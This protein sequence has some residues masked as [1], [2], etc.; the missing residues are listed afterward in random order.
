MTVISVSRLPARNAFLVATLS[1]KA[2]TIASFIDTSLVK[3]LYPGYD[4][5]LLAARD[6][7]IDGQ[8]E[9]LTCGT[10]SLGK[11]APFVAKTLKTPLEV[12]RHGII[13]LALNPMSGK[14][15]F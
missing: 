13:N 11:V 2:A 6:F 9:H 15:I 3:R 12:K 14:K 8:R 4:E 7:R 10:F 5:F 1:S